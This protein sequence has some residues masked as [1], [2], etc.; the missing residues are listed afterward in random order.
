MGVRPVGRQ[1][2]PYAV[3][4]RR[5]LTV[6]VGLTVTAAAMLFV[7]RSTPMT[8]VA[9]ASIFIAAADARGAEEASAGPVNPL[10]LLGDLELARGV[11]LESLNARGVSERIA[12]VAPNATYEIVPDPSSDAPI[13]IFTTEAPTVRESTE[14]LETL[15]RAVPPRLSQIQ[16]NLRIPAADRVTVER[17]TFDPGY[18][19]SRTDEVRGAIAV[20][21]AGLL[22]TFL[23]AVVADR[24]RLGRRGARERQ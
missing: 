3:L 22:A 17:L 15:L 2:G 12:R 21:G 20:A 14:A 24:R 1:E 10:L 6:L 4:R 9:R 23:L 19:T 13:L 5:W 11:V 18:G 16:R 7:I 8:Y